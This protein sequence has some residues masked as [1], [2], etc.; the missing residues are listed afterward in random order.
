MDTLIRL[1][2]T[3][4]LYAVAL[5][6]AVSWL[7]SPRQTKAPYAVAA[8]LAAGLVGVLVK[9]AGTA[10]TDPRPFVVDHTTPLIAHSVDNG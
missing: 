6:A 7:R 4:A 5:V 8:V 3:Y 2:A 1:T 9:V 10:W